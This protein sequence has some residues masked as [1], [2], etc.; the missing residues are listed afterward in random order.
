MGFR[1]PL[2][3]IGALLVRLADGTFVKADSASVGEWQGI[4]QPGL[5][6]GD[7]GGDGMQLHGDRL[8]VFISDP[9]AMPARTRF[10]VYRGAGTGRLYGFLGAEELKVG[11]GIIQTDLAGAQTGSIPDLSTGAGS[12]T[13][14]AS[15]YLTVSHDGWFTPVGVLVTPKS[16]SQVV[17]DT[18]TGTTFRI[19]CFDRTGAILASTAITFS[20]L[21]WG[22]RSMP[23]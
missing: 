20:W 10:Y 22:G 3:V 5:V 17:A 14:D 23:Q 9:G 4:D 18:F 19:R 1:N 6:W 2:A 13:T 16:P 12:G 11:G 7:S 8:G 21:A 15:G